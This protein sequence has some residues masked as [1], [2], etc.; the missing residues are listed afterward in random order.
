MMKCLVVFLYFGAFLPCFYLECKGEHTRSWS[1]FANLSAVKNYEHFV[2]TSWSCIWLSVFSNFIKGDAKILFCDTWFEIISTT[3]KKKKNRKQ[4]ESFLFFLTIVYIH[5]HRGCSFLTQ[6]VQN[7]ECKYK[8][9]TW[10][11]FGCLEFFKYSV[12]TDSFSV[13]FFL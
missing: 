1:E 13:L 11:W 10:R 5:T 12:W 4:R 8:L 2:S 7:V 9:A 3:N 6:T